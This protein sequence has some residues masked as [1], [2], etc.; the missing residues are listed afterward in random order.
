MACADP[1]SAR[2]LGLSQRCVRCGLCQPHCPTYVLEGHESE[3]PRGRITLAEALAEDR[4]G[5]GTPAAAAAIDHCLG[6]RRCE[7]ACPAGVE[8]D[9]L[10][11]DARTLLRR[12]LPAALPQRVLEAAI[13]RRWPLAL[14]WPLLRTLRLLIPSRWRRR[15]PAIPA[16]GP[17]SGLHPALS[18]RRGRVALFTGCLARRLDADVHRSAIA[19]LTRLGWEVLVPGEILCCGALHRHAGDPDGAGLEAAAVR[20]WI[21]ALP[22]CSAVLVPAS[23]CFEDLRRAPS[24]AGPPVRELMAHVADDPELG[25]LSLRGGNGTLAVHTPCTQSTAVGRADAAAAVLGQVPGFTLAVLPD[26]GCCGAAG[27]HV[28]LHP[29]RADAQREG[30]LAAAGDHGAHTLVSG[31]IG[32]RLHLATGAAEAGS[33]L[34]VR[35]PIQI[36]AEHLP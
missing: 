33:A 17:R 28:L 25:R 8:F 14:A 22:G 29:G 2:L 9:Q 10:L 21:D 11:V 7:A 1:V 15:I 31:N 27:S 12:T 26:S 34:R 23:G 13:A 24:A 20:R 18:E 6:C 3:S 5:D 16:A 30:L 32:C 19:V 36:L 4:L 35:H